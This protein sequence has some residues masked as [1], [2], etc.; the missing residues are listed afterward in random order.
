MTRIQFKNCYGAYRKMSKAVGQRQA[1]GW[2]AHY[3][4][5]DARIMARVAT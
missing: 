2:I 5:P 3:S 1:L 4:I